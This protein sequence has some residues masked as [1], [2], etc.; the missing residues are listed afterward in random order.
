[1]MIFCEA[2]SVFKENTHQ[3]NPNYYKTAIHPVRL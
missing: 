2:C 1:M 3:I